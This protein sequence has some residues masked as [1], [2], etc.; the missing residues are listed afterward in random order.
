[1]KSRFRVVIFSGADPA[2]ILRLVQRIHREVPE[3]RVCGVL[4]ERRSG[5]SISARASAFARNLHDLDFLQYAGSRLWASVSEA[6]SQSSSA[7]LRFV[8]GGGPTVRSAEDPLRILESLGCVFRV[9]SDYHCEKS[10]QFVRSLHPD[11]GIVY[12]T[13]ILKRSLFSIPRCGSINIHKRKVPDYRGGGPVGLWEM[14]DGREEIGVTVHQVTEHLDA[15]GIV[16]SSTIPIEPFDN[17]TSLAL[18]A[19][20]T[21]NDLLVRSVADYSKGIVNLKQQTGSGRMFKAPSPQRLWKLKRQLAATRTSYRPSGSRPMLKMCAKTLLAL[22]RVTVRNWKRRVHGRFPVNIL[23]HHLLADRQH[24]LGISTEYF[25]RHVRFLQLYY[26]IVSLE[27]AIEMLDSN[28]VK[29]PTVVL[30]FDDGYRDNFINLRAV[31]EETGVPVTMFISSDHISRGNEFNHDLECDH[32]GFF[33]LTWMQLTQMRADGFEI[34]SHTRTHFDCGSGDDGALQCEIV[35]SK[36]ELEKH[37]GQTIKFFSFPFGLPVNISPQA[38]AIAGRTYPYILSACG[39]DN[40][41]PADGAVRHLRR[42]CHPNRLWD[43][44]LQLQGVL[45]QPMLLEETFAAT[46]RPETPVSFAGKIVLPE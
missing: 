1:M 43:L 20:V 9:T 42:W 13:R 6:A 2:P 8:H 4:S 26:D 5:K 31:V 38:A 34:G 10:L 32:H 29:R 40:S 36:E 12:G 33:P 14:L 22:P 19:H 35:G 28:N 30:T 7:L 37:L 24:R 3:V 44:E 16:H 15:G 17:L 45:E 39:G 23:F 27:T 25:L 21:A 41:V 46:A 18:K 11:L